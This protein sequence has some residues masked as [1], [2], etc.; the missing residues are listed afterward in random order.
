MKLAATLRATFAT[1]RLQSQQAQ[2]DTDRQ[3]E[4]VSA[5]YPEAQA[6]AVEICHTKVAQW[7]E[8]RL[9]GAALLLALCVGV[10]VPGALAAAPPAIA[11]KTFV[12]IGGIDQ[13]V[14]IKGDDRANPVVLFL[15]GGPGN[16]SSPFA[17]AWYAGWEKHFTL[18]QWDQRG[19]GRTFTRNGP[20]V[21]PTMTVERMVQDGIEVAEFLTR[22]LH[23]RKIILVGGSWGSI[24]GVSMAHSRPDLFQAYVG[25]AQ[26]VS[27]RDDLVASYVRVLELARADGDLEAVATLT[28]LGPPPWDSLAKW[29]KFHRI[30]RAYQ[31]KRTTAPDLP[32]TIAAEYASAEEAA[33]R[34][35][36]DDFSFLHFVGPTMAGPLTGVDLAPLGTDFAVPIY[37]IQG[38]ED[39]TAAP[40][41]ARIWF[42]RIKAP[43][44]HFYLVPGTGHYPSVPQMA[45]ALTVLETE[46]IPQRPGRS[47]SK[48]PGASPVA[49]P[50]DHSP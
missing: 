1:L 39:L 4:D 8:R 19:A 20:G 18:V 44:K 48:R 40:E 37:I 28:A 30:E 50:R 36:A 43:A 14:T 29:P 11:E 12:A 31:A 15:H 13:W 10:A 45:L 23:K 3:Q 17:D 49:A 38:Q 41:L 16:A 21:E 6:L 42:D 26:M 46:V 2:I 22:H 5:L 47:R 7:L 33:Q 35:A 9:V 24:L 32:E 34:E 27:W 25:L